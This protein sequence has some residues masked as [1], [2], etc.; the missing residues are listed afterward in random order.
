MECK[1]RELCR[2]GGFRVTDILL[3]LAGFLR[4]PFGNG[5]SSGMSERSDFRVLD[6]GCGKGATVEYLREKFPSWEVC[7]IDKNPE[8]CADGLVKTA[9]AEELPFSDASLDVIFMECSLS[10]T[11]NPEKALQEAFRVLKPDGW[12]LISDMYARKK[13]LLADG[14][15]GRLE[16]ADRIWRRLMKA[17]FSVLEMQD[18]SGELAQWV[19]QQIMDGNGKVLEGALGADRK[20]LREAGSGYYYCAARP[21]T[22]WE[23][24]RYAWEKSP[25][26]QEKFRESGLDEAVKPGDWESFR[27]LPFTTPEDIRENPERFLCVPAKEIARIITLRTSGS[28]GKPKR[29]FFTEDDLMRTADFYEVGMQ[30]LVKPGDTVTVYMEGPGLFSVGGLLKEGL[31][32]IQVEVR[33]HGLI[34]DMEAA[35]RDGEGRDCFVGVPGQMYSLAV[36]APWL[37]PKTVLLSAD[38]VP[39]SVLQF[40]E[41]TWKC[42]VFTHWAMTETGYGG[43]VQCT[44]RG[45]YHMRDGDLL[46]EVID[47]DTGLSVPEGEYG[48]LVLTTFHRRGMPL[49]RYR[50]GD[51]GRYLLEP[52]GCGCLKPCLAKVEGRLDD[53][54]CLP[55]G[56]LLSMHILDELLLSSGEIQDFEAAY[57]EKKGHLILWTMVGRAETR[58]EKIREILETYFDGALTVLVLEKEVSPYI[59]SGKRKI[60]LI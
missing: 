27:Q 32:R 45:G 49:I 51:V 2:P 46:L 13:E 34:R 21:S 50:T 16:L 10:K 35:A 53:V 7:G 37:R 22:L 54:I 44:A 11:E 57:D 29:L 55:G 58:L 12:L 17:G 26:Y 41:E 19:G 52:C 23:T 38:Y 28:S 43:G 1:G 47:P 18:V 8:L 39:E 40:L 56:K 4:Q 30:Y 60:Q 6:V 33:V 3:R 9:C 36:N 48:E 42:R 20:A 5:V 25:F 31:S 59:G 24:V 14:M 15:L